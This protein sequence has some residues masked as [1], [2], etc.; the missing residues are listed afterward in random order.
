MEV[1]NML[2]GKITFASAVRVASPL[3]FSAMAGVFCHTSGVFNFAYECFLLCGAFFAAFG[4]YISGSYLV[5]ALFATVS[6]LLLATVFG[7]F[8]FKLKANEFIVSIALNMS[9]WAL[10]TLLL[11]VVWDTRGQ[12]VSRDI[13]NFPKIHLAFL[14]KFPA[15][16]YMFNDNTWMSYAAFLSVIVAWVVMYRSRFGLHVRGVGINAP[17]A[18]TC[19]VNVMKTRWI[20]LLLMGSVTGLAGSYFPMSGLNTFSENMTSGSGMLVFA[21]ILV[22]KG[23]P[24]LTAFICFMFAYTDALSTVLTALHFPTQL[25]AMIPYITVIVTLFL[26]NVRHFNGKPQVN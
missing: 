18:Q 25:V 22:G 9:A 15:I 8:V 20:S 6:G 7:I 17:A 13:I 26:M 14:E 11:T 12:I 16:D 10:T 2:F 5:G 3:V 23:N 24:I 4:S 1:L 21:S 19:G